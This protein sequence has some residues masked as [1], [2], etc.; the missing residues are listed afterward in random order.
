MEPVQ[1]LRQNKRINQIVGTGCQVVASS[2]QSRIS[3]YLLC[4]SQKQATGCDA[5]INTQNA[6]TFLSQQSE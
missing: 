1:P 5:K 4:L 2:G 3:L 6:T